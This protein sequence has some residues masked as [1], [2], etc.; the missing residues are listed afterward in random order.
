MSGAVVPREPHPLADLFPVLEGEA[1]DALANDIRHHGLRV[2]IT[3]FEEKILDGRN[4]YAA[5]LRAGVEPRFE[6]WRGEGSPLAWVVSVN[7]HRRHLSESQRA[8][9]GARAKALFEAEAKGRQIA[10][11]RSKVPASLPEAGEAR[12]H[13]AKLVN[14]SPRSIEDGSC[15]IGK[16][17]PELVRAVET[18]EMAVSQAAKIAA[19]QKGR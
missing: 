12:A 17:A 13:A 6:P 16:G 4:R 11:G 3:L 15:V 14:V 18:G 2:P 7:L 1:L 10:G 8:I 5:C 19:D 9:V